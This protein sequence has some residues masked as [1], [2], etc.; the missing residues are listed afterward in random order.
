[1]RRG[2]RE[3]EAAGR[4]KEPDRAPRRVL[5]RGRDLRHLRRRCSAAARAEL[6]RL[7]RQAYPSPWR[8]FEADLPGHAEIGVGQGCVPVW[9]TLA[10]SAQGVE[11]RFEWSREEAERR[12]R[13]GASSLAR[14]MLERQ[15][16]D[17]ARRVA[18][19]TRL[20]LAAGPY[21]NGESLTDLLLHLVFAKACFEDSAPPRSRS[22]FEAAVDGGRERLY[23][24]L[25]DVAAAARTWFAEARGVRRLLDD[26][27]AKSA[28]ELASGEPGASPAVIRYR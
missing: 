9:P 7:A 10:A 19:D 25:E 6:D 17:L 12:F 20:V 15:A 24:A 28:H 23:P 1:M 22:L 16:K 13:R 3:L 4:A 5:A 11:V 26:P 2:T 21:L 14:L 8:R 18:A 27:R